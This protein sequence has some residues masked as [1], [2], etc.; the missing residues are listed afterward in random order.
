MPAGP[1]HQKGSPFMMANSEAP[2]PSHLCNDSGWGRGTVEEIC[3]ACLVV[4]LIEEGLLDHGG[5]QGRDATRLH[6]LLH[7]DSAFLMLLLMVCMS[8]GFRLIR[9]ITCMHDGRQ[10]GVRT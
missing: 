10:Q 3:S 2:R 6:A 4:Q 1:A 7:D 8:K 9:S 5:Q